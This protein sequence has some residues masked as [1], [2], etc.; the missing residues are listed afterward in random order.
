MATEVILPRQGQSVESCIIL[1]WKKAE[2][3]EVSEGEVLVEVETDKASFEVESSASGILLKQLVSEGD[4]VPVL[5]PLAL[6]GE[7]GEDV[8]G[9]E[10][11]AERPESGVAD[12]AASEPATP[13]STAA[14]AEREAAAKGKTATSRS[15][16][17]TAD[18]GGAPSATPAD[19]ESPLREA[20]GETYVSP[21][22]RNIA[23]AKGVDVS[24]ISGSG[25]GGRIIERDIL[26]A[27]DSREPL[28]PAAIE[29]IIE[30]GKSAPAVGTGPGGRVVSRDLVAAGEPKA[31]AAASAGAAA[32]AGAL[33]FPG[34]VEEIEVKGVRKLIAERMHASLL[35]SAQL[36]MNSAADARAILAYRKKVKA[37][38]EAL[39]LSQITINDLI[40][41][42]VS[43]ALLRYPEMNATMSEGVIRRY[44][45]VH[46]GFA[47]DTPRG[48][49]VPVVRNA[50]ARTLKQ[51]G[52]ETSRLATA[53]LDGKID[54]D[55]LS[56][57]TFTVT[58][59]GN[60]GV[61]SFTPVLNT[62]QVGILGVG[63][64]EPKPTLVDG[65]Y[66][67]IPHIGLSITIDHR[68]VDGAPGARFMQEVA[69]LIAN[70]ELALAG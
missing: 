41:F 27:L 14:E 8:S 2:G 12:S 22:A 17:E 30:T 15:V 57:G 45:H 63:S 10:A 64:I 4:D 35:E 58:N 29:E 28:S 60:L 19:A 62:P 50:H 46:L 6:V 47:V 68:A 54:P 38:D 40:L 31:G 5:A 67:F 39:G 66:Q 48:L 11:S 53:C 43:R 1:E 59:L 7:A 49:M 18:S 3:D 37:A 20:R 21:R 55:E 61:S 56:G 24:T 34:P 13:T 33:E 32:A 9:Y 70:V 23:A 65:E 16:G 52:S 25:P 44:E 69:R 26:A 36:T 51:I 42:A